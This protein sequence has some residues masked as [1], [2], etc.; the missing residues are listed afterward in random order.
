MRALH[1]A[2]VGGGHVDPVAFWSLRP[3]ACWWILEDRCPH[4]FRT[5]MAE[6]QRARLR[7]LYREAKAKEAMTDGQ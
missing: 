6:T 7:R 2:L 4:L 3:R 5:P 1:A